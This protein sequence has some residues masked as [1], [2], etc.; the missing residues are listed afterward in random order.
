M[1]SVIDIIQ[2]VQVPQLIKD[3]FIA[4]GTIVLDSRGRPVHY[5]GGFAV[6]FPVVVDGE[7][8]AFRCWCADIGNVEQRLR[9]LSDELKK[10]KIPYFC[11]FSYIPNGIVV[12]GTIYPV[13]H[14]KWVDG[15]TIKDYVCSNKDN[16]RK[17]EKLASSF[18]TMCNVLHK[19]CIAHGDLQHGNILVDEKGNLFLIDYD[20]VYLPNLEG[21]DDIITGLADYQHPK[22]K[23]NKKASEKLDYFSELIIYLSLR[24]VAKRP[25]LIE[26]YQIENADRL[27]FSKEDFQD[28]ENSSIFQD[29]ADLG[30]EYQELL[31]VLKKYLEYQDINE[32][33]PFEEVLLE[34]KIEFSA[35]TVKAVRNTQKIT[36]KWNVP[37][38]AKVA[39]A[40][41][42]TDYRQEY[43]RKGKIQTSL[44]NDTDFILIVE[45]KSKVQIRK[46]IQIKVFDECQID[47]K[48]DKYYIYPSIPVMLSW[49]VKYAKK[50]WFDSEKVKA[51]GTRVVEPERATS[52]VLS[53]EDEFGKKERRIEIQMLPIPQVRTLLV[54]TP[55]LKNNLSLTVLQPRFNAGVTF[56]KIEMKM[57][58][59]KLP[60]VSSLTDLGI[61]VEL[62][63][64]LPKLGV[65]GS[66][67]KMF[68]LLKWK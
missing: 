58:T 17:L 55:K 37:F 50:V 28:L 1:L 33:H 45:T 2:S 65:V 57:I 13:T 38:D 24:A 11:E 14:M 68:N 51:K 39:L 43:K 47:F 67:K 52:Y 54:P 12:N 7:K 46:T 15:R 42:G 60:E 62:S 3:D 64:P 63:P 32:L 4:T 44:S 31:D 30:T 66:I 41:S 21:A 34:K 25:S 35:S 53:A 49:N 29:I 36:L 22:R 18:I 48:A 6:V 23:E 27:L 59:M 5:T 10:L 8:Y 61:N 19:H 56:P 20:S 16:P 40:Q 9:L 26:Q